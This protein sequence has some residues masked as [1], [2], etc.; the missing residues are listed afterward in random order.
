MPRSADYDS[1]EDLR[2]SFVSITD[3]SRGY[4]TSLED[5]TKALQ[6]CGRN[7]SS[8]QVEH[9]WKSYRSMDIP[10]YRLKKK[11]NIKFN[12]IFNL[13]EINEEDFIKIASNVE[14]INGKE[15]LEAFKSIDS[16]RNGYIS[17]R[18]LQTLFSSVRKFNF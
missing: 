2:A 1:V 15:L 13:E 4:I 10:F 9:Y 7:P 17:T 8:K 3:S 5:L 11:Y 12:S 16:D 18:E 14:K 6:I